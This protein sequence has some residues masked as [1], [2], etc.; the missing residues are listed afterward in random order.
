MG[1]AS[2]QVGLWLVL[3]L[4]LALR[5]VGAEEPPLVILGPA[6][7]DSVVVWVQTARPGPVELNYHKHPHGARVATAVGRTRAESHLV[8]RLHL[9][10]LEP[11]VRYCGALWFEG[12]PVP[13][14][15]QTK[16]PE[17][18]DITIAF[19]SCVYVNDPAI[20]KG[21][22][23]GEY[24]IFEQ[25]VK[26]A[27]DLMLWLGD[28]VYY[29]PGDWDSAQAMRER[30]RKD[31]L[32]LPNLGPL[33]A[34]TQ[35]YAIWDDHD[36]GPNNGDSS[37]PHKDEAL[38]VF[39]QV[40]P[41]GTYGQ[42]QIPGAFYRFSWADVDFF[43]LDD[44]YYRTQ[45][46][47][48]GPAQM[49]WLKQQLESSQAPF[50]LV[51]GGCQMLNPVAPYEAWAVYPR[52]RQELLDFIA[53]ERIEGVVFL[54]G[55]RHCAE[56]IRLDPKGGYP[57]YEFTSSPLTSSLH[58]MTPEEKE[59][60]ARVSGSWFSE[61]R[62]YGLA[63]ISGPTGHRLLTLECKDSQGQLVWTL[64]LKE[65]ELRFSL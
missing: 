2:R 16:P 4:G 48:Y 6:T 22:S 46:A 50:K 28:N 64:Q 14:T 53:Q 40:W 5:L 25:I 11:G 30:T 23:G 10:G 1:Q 37:F 38:E 17:P 3:F 27:P 45:E 31:R 26:E 24:E 21:E 20:P 58:Q 65:R 13:V 60:P 7:G 33:F 36:F 41:G 15:F 29:R 42:D 12:R 43:M 18:R 47:M 9:T 52:E 44:R 62:N 32:R 49:A 35:N 59:N 19:G 57:L 63:R 61:R 56:L 54:S 51:V 34:N 8:E 39:R 55:D